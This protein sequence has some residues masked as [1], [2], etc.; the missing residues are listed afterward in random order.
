MIFIL[1]HAFSLRGSHGREFTVQFGRNTFSSPSV[2]LLATSRAIAD[3][4]SVLHLPQVSP[5]H[6]SPCTHSSFP[7]RR[8]S[9]SWTIQPHPSSSS[10]TSLW[11][12]ATSPCLSTASPATRLQ[13]SSETM[14]QAKLLTH[15]LRCPGELGKLYHTTSPAGLTSSKCFILMILRCQPA[16]LV[17][18][19]LT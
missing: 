1:L 13:N 16:E 3:F 18:K 15:D 5:P 17:P 19:V 9:R 8:R 14:E 4:T 2:H 11:P 12:Q 10:T 6:Q 7:Y